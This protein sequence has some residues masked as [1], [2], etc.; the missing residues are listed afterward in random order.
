MSLS[1][2]LMADLKQAMKDRNKVKLDTVRMIKADLMNEKIKLGHDLK[3]DEE[4]ALLSREKK[5]REE[6][7]AEFSKANR[8][9]L[10]EQTQKELKIVAAYLPKPL[11]KSELTQIVE[12][13]INEVG[14]KDKSDFG[15][16]MKT[17][18]PKVKGRADGKQA[19][20]LVR[21]HLN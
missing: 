17:L 3:P 5:Q 13:T 9:D 19:S 14:A 2:Q 4:L 8:K 21:E 7:I 11:S 1:D 20:M 18:M 15:R 12:Q 10:V 16:V 6:S